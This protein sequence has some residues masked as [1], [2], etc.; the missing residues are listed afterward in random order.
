M[1]RT[2]LH[3]TVHTGRGRLPGLSGRHTVRPVLSRVA[4][5]V[6]ADSSSSASLAA[7]LTGQGMQVRGVAS[8]ADATTEADSHPFDVVIVD[9]DLAGGADGLPDILKCFGEIPVVATGSTGPARA[10]EA[11]RSGAAD[12]LAKPFDQAEVV[13]VLGKVLAAISV[14]PTRP[15]AAEMRESGL[16]GQSKAMGHVLDLVRRVAAGNATVLVRGE[17]GT[18]K[19]LVARAIH[20]DSQRGDGPFVKVH[21]AGL[22]ETLL[23]SELFGYEKGAF[24]GAASRK[25]GRVEIAEGGTL[26]LDEIGDISPAVQVK[27][28]RLLQDREYERLGGTATLRADVRFV[29]ATHRDLEDMIRKGEFREDLF[30]RLNVVPIWLP[31]LRA[32]RDDV[33]LLAASFCA[34]FAEAH[35]K[36]GTVL[37]SDAVA[38][39]TAERW[40]GNVRQLQNFVERLVVLSESGAISASHVRRELAPPVTFST[41]SPSGAALHTAVSSMGTE[42]GPASTVMPLDAVLRDAERHAIERA[43]RHSKGNRTLAARLLGVSRAT[44]YTKLEEHGLGTRG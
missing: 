12:F 10:S 43:L 14:D 25:P 17:S 28:L 13:Y 37:S 21:C 30:Y 1:R 8:L 15:P 32:R 40:P 9:W 24:T 19:E 39:L 26:F 22:P 7:L 34:A 18:G 29:A 41:Q 35:D 42:A 16:L 5:I 4:L 3:P 36:R 20:A 2:S 6:D 38:A 11:L 23:E 44:F 33:A 27:L 31:P